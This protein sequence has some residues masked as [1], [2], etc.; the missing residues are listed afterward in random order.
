M[1]S[2][3]CGVGG[4]GLDH[5]DCLQLA[6]DFGDVLVAVGEELQDDVDDGPGDALR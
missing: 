2:G 1:G 5:S 4:E 6:Q 3:R